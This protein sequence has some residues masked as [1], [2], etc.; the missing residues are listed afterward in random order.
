MVKYLSKAEA[1]NHFLFNP[2]LIS[3]LT[4]QYISKYIDHNQSLVIIFF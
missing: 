3:V 1:Y 4:R 2:H